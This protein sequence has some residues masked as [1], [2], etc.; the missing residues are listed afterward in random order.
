[1]IKPEKAYWKHILTLIWKRVYTVAKWVFKTL[2][3]PM[4]YGLGWIVGHAI[5]PAQ[6]RPIKKSL[7]AREVFKKELSKQCKEFKIRAKNYL[8]FIE[9]TLEPCF[10]QDGDLQENFKKFEKTIKDIE[11]C[12][13]ALR[14]EEISF[15]DA[16]ADFKKIV[17]ILEEHFECLQDNIR[18][19][20]DYLGPLLYQPE[21]GIPSWE[22]STV[23]I[24]S[25]IFIVKLI[26]IKS[27][28][29]SLTHIKLIENLSEESV[30]V[31][32]DTGVKLDTR[33]IKK[34]GVED[35]PYI[36][37]FS[38]G[39]KSYT[40]TLSDLRIMADTCNATVIGFDYPNVGRST[41]W[42]YSSEQLVQ[43][44]IAQVQRLLD[45]GVAVDKITLHGHI[46][47]GSIATQVAAH[48]HDREKDPLTLNL[49]NDRSA[50]NKSSQIVGVYPSLIAAVIKF[51]LEPILL[52]IDWEMN[53]VDAYKK[54]P[55]KSK[56]IIVAKSDQ[57]IPYK[58]ASLYQAIKPD[59]KAQFYNSQSK[60]Y[61][62]I[63][64]KETY[65]SITRSYKVLKN[66]LYD[67]PLYKFKNKTGIPVVES[68]NTFV[69]AKKTL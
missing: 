25:R 46:L 7:T 28:E 53:V 65:K 68:V 56:M 30:I 13:L 34:N 67:R 11:N 45:R 47:G 58:E 27:M 21:D 3:T 15:N 60:E 44:G 63:E 52:W 35:P 29:K 42:V 18:I 9:E 23:T 20:A 62:S 33:E 14:S 1:M 19:H 55:Q 37:K 59:L 51:I 61:N 2:A 17:P 54:I 49:I 10:K 8:K 16:V 36:I 50:S 4:R 48:F 22:R 12:I 24:D 5:L 41:G 31:T 38:S 40:E 43:A 32:T 57:N 66:Q 64:D 6:W 26:A 69:H 39:E